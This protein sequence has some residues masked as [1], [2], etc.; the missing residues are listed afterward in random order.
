MALTREQV[1]DTAFS[2]LRDYG[3]ADLSMRR[4]ARDLDVQPGALYW[5]V[6]NKQ[7]LLGVLAVMI[8]APVK[9]QDLDGAGAAAVIES[10]RLA[11]R[12]IRD[13]LLAVRDGAEVVALTH[14]LAPQSLPAL[15]RFTETLAAA[16]L[17]GRN[18]TW[19][20]R[21]LVNYILGSVTQEQTQ[22]GLS[23][24]GLLDSTARP[25]DDAD[26]FNF[27]LELLLAGAAA[28]LHKESTQQRDSG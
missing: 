6:K 27:G 11:S 3:I 4:L 13:A 7:D 2:I 10:L 8:L 22:S 16:G 15:Q 17:S 26:A 1:I 9:P 19:T 23:Q 18:P 14:T 12:Q 24:A 28:L 20:G 5:H 25:V 21:A